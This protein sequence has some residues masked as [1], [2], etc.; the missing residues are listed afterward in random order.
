MVIFIV[1]AGFLAFGAVYILPSRSPVSTPGTFGIEHFVNYGGQITDIEVDVTADPARDAHNV[2][3]RVFTTPTN[4]EGGNYIT[5]RLL[6]P[7]GV[8]VQPCQT[9]CQRIPGGVKL[10]ETIQVIG[11]TAQPNPPRWL[12]TLKMRVVGR[13]FAFDANG[14]TAE[15]QIPSFEVAPMLV[16]FVTVHYH[17]PDAASYDWGG[18]PAAPNSVAKNEASWHESLINATSTTP[19]DAIDHGAETQDNTLV[20]TAGIFLGIAGAALIAGVQELFQILKDTRT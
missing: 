20:F 19:V 8:S 1:A 12:A 18:A 16:K 3:I 5:A 14:V 2:R 13:P 4:A 11:G 6:L 15:A 10:T 9:N 17:I 7:Q